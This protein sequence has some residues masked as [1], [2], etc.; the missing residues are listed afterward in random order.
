MIIFVLGA[1][2]IISVALYLGFI[3][4]VRVGIEAGHWDNIK[5]E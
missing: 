2:V 1:V 4:G 5:G 3:F